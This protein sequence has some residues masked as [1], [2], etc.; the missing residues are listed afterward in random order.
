MARML[1]AVVVMLSLVT[2]TVGATVGGFS[3]TEISQGNVFTIEALDLRVAR[4]YGCFSPIDYREDLPWGIGLEPLFT[5]DC[6]DMGRPYVAYAMI[7]NVGTLDGIAQLHIRVAED[8]AGIADT[9]QLTVWY[10]DNGNRSIE[11]GEQTSGTL[12]S[13]DCTPLTLGLLPVD[14][15]RTMKITVR[16][17]AEP[18]DPLVG[19]SLMF[20]TEFGL[21]QAD[22]DGFSDTETAHNVF[23]GCGGEGCTPGFW[24]NNLTEWWLTGY[25]PMHTIESVFNVP[26][27]LPSWIGQ[28]SLLDALSFP[29]GSGAT[30]AAQILLRSAVAAVLNAAH[31]LVSYSRAESTIIA[32]VNAAMTSPDF[33]DMLELAEALDDD[34]NLHC[35][36]N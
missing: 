13:F 30:G 34:N 28:T 11:P 4:W 21:I 12:Q 36:L 2:I 20:D 24:K 3:D 17:L 32:E 22:C 8:T 31:P 14:E 10:D 35:P 23:I 9:T 15:T 29:G 33:M 19:F 27:S 18:S 6:T 1:L 26:G 5:V 16:P 25:Y 7:W